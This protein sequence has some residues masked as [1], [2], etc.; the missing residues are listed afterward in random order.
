MVEVNCLGLKCPMP[1]IATKKALLE[2]PGKNL[3]ILIDNETSCSNLKTYLSDNGIEFSVNEL[4][5]IFYFE[6][7]ST[8]IVAPLKEEASYC[9][10]NAENSRF[11]VVLDSA[12]M[13][14]G[15]T[16]LGSILLKGFLTALSESDI[17]PDE[18]ICYNGGVVLASS[19]SQFSGYLKKIADRDVKI[20]LCGTCVDYYGIKDKLVAGNI[21]NMMYILSR[22]SSTL[23]IVK[24]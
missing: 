4:K 16:E 12:E 22:L 9:S 14:R 10:S 2:N 5:G 20:T 18:V 11:I 24:P 13:G 1:L 19:E 7:G 23:K 3:R 21:S 15:S 17:L 6:T 8:P